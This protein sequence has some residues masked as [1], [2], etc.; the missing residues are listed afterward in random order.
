M[1]FWIFIWFIPKIWPVIHRLWPPPI[2]VDLM[3]IASINRGLRKDADI[4]DH[5]SCGNPNMFNQSGLLKYKG[6][7]WGDWVDKEVT[8]Q[9]TIMSEPCGYRWLIMAGS[10]KKTSPQVIQVTNF[11]PEPPSMSQ[12]W[13]QHDSIE[14]SP[15]QCVVTEAAVL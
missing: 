7:T 3:S 14:Q 2:P 12:Q 11:W 10:K 15:G 9:K 8:W 1:E 4:D 5:H 13:F 6:G